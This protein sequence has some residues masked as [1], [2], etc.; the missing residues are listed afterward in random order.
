[1]NCWKRLYQKPI[2][3]QSNKEKERLQKYYILRDE[4]LKNH[5]LCEVCNKEKSTQ[6][7]HRKGRLG[8]NLFNYFLAICDEDHKKVEMNPEWAYENNYSLL[9]N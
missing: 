5:P 4:Y 8:N 2:P 1:M 3:K 7:H 9:R 6:I